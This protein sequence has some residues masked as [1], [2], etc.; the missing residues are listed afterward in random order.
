MH[1]Y[2]LVKKI[3]KEAMNSHTQEDLAEISLSVSESSGLDPE[4]IRLY[5]QD[6]CQELPGLKAAKLNIRLVK[7]KL[8]CQ[9]CNFDFERIEKSFSCPKCSGESGRS[10]F[11]KDVYIEN[12]KFKT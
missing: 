5:F 2:H 9:K 11:Y 1:E 10:P 8:Y 12:L 7:V 6:I 3:V 4:S